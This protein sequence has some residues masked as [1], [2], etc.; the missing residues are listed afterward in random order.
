[1]TFKEKSEKIKEV[2]EREKTAL[3]KLEK[4]E[5]EWVINFLKN[6]NEE[7]EDT[8]RFVS[9]LKNNDPARKFLLYILESDHCYTK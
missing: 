8:L 6:P 4:E 5:I 1:M 2:L 3:K 9:F 7:V